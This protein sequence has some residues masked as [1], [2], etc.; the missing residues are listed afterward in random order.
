MRR[1]IV[2]AVLTVAVC[3]CSGDGY[4]GPRQIVLIRHADKLHQEHYGHC[5]SPKGQVRAETFAI[6]YMKRFGQPDFLFAT[7]PVSQK[8]EYSLREV[9][10][11]APLANLLTR[12]TQEGVMIYQPYPTEKFPQMARTLLRD[13]DYRGK[14]ILVCWDHYNLP[15]FMKDLN[16]TDEVPPPSEDVFDTVYVMQYNP[17]RSIK[18]FEI[19]KNQYPVSDPGSWE[20]LACCGQNCAAKTGD[21]GS[22]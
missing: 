7:K 4:K 22:K 12:L 10:T 19:L 13:K 1:L 20:N 6:Y 17:D 2:V 11:L 9:Q 3:G 5:L 18:K 14:D 8:Y 21:E 15:N 16:V